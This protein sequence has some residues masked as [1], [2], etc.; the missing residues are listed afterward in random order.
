MRSLLIVIA[1]LFC[2]NPIWAL[3]LTDIPSTRSN[4]EDFQPATQNQDPRSIMKGV[5]PF[6]VDSRTDE[7]MI[8][9]CTTCHDGES[10]LP[11]NKIRKLEMMHAD[12]NLV[13]GNGRFWC[14]TCHNLNLR[15]QLTSFKG[16]IIS[17]NEPYLLCGQCHQKVQKDFFFGA[18]GKRKHSWK[19]ERVLT[20]CT[21][22]HDPHVPQI[23]P[24]NARSKPAVRAG[25][26]YMKAPVQHHK[27]FW[28]NH[29]LEI[30][31]AKP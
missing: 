3:D 18:H 27:P 26:P 2:S 31:P 7:M 5:P 11:N 20:N 12:V 23:A 8:Y 30:A 29:L 6:K 25:L 24:R 15:D 10:V 4:P 19:G 14:T 17:F 22:C 21:E 16:Q 9:P 28:P 13:H 1:F